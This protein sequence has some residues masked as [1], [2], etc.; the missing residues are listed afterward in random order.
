MPVT[1]VEVSHSFGRPLFDPI[2]HTFAPGRLTGI[3]GPSG[4]GKSTL[5]GIVAGMIRPTTGRVERTSARCTWVFQNPH[6]VAQRRVLDH[7]SLPSLARGAPRCEADAEARELLTTFGLGDRADVTFGALSG[8]E[9]QRLMLA[10]AVASRPDL[11]LVDEPTAQLDR[12]MAAHVNGVM[13]HL[14]G[15]GA[16][17]VI[18]THDPATRDACDEIIDLASSGR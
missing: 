15:S 6:G 7:L 16:A 5:L 4:C 18:A 8:G 2:S 14:A 13:G 12:A 9:A 17:V 1:L 3:V 10:R 11:L